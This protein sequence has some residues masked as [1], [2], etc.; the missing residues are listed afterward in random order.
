MNVGS[1]RR[2]RLVLDSRLRGNRRCQLVAD[3][4]T[5]ENQEALTLT[6]I[7]SQDGRGGFRN[8]ICEGMTEGKAKLKRSREAPPSCL[9]RT[10]IACIFEL[11]EF[12]PNMPWNGSK[13]TG[14]I[15]KFEAVSVSEKNNCDC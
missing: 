8:S 2:N 14:V 3:A 9:T 1:Q 10:P 5:F 12:L 4:V 6:S 11:P 7:L 13:R 15:V